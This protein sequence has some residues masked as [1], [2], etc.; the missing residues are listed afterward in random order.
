MDSSDPTSATPPTLPSLPH[1][2]LVAIAKD[3]GAIDLCNLASASLPL[4]VTVAALWSSIFPTR[5]PGRLASS[6]SFRDQWLMNM[7]AIDDVARELNSTQKSLPPVA[8]S[9]SVASPDSPM[10]M[11]LSMLPA[12]AGTRMAVDG[13]TSGSFFTCVARLHDMHAS[14]PMLAEWLDTRMAATS[15]LGCLAVLR[16]LRTRDAAPPLQQLATRSPPPP[17]LLAQVTL[18][19]ST[20]SNLRDCRGFRARDDIHRRSSRLLDLARCPVDEEPHG[21]GG[22]DAADLWAI[23]HRGVADEVRS[24]HLLAE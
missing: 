19:W 16:V 5:F 3:L 9:T 11:S 15:P 20:W 6:G 23:L 22:E 21:F 18:R 8:S 1:D 2:C 13:V 7:D 10:A 24:I 4:S 12:G 14:P 17:S